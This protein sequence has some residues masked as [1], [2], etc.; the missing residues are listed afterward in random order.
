MN[1][2]LFGGHIV[3]LHEY[4]VTFDH[5]FL[6]SVADTK[7]DADHARSSLINEKITELANKASFFARLY[8]FH[9]TFALTES[10]PRRLEW[11]F[12]GSTSTML[13]LNKTTQNTGTSSTTASAV[14][15]GNQRS[16]QTKSLSF[17]EQK[18]HKL[19]RK[20]SHH[21]PESKQCHNFVTCSEHP[22]KL[23]LNL[24]DQEILSANARK[25]SSVL[26]AT[27]RTRKECF[28]KCNQS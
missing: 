7:L 13:F 25:P 24:V 14:S 10:S 27:I 9:Y 12:S 1:I 21:T 5:L 19:K 18:V 22:S 8:T 17:Q 15:D 16:H 6:Y 4:H 3:T 20:G 11:L 26:S 2:L 23:Q 28:S